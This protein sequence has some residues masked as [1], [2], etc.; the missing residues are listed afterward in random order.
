MTQQL[1]ADMTA[2]AEGEATL[3]EVARG[4][5]RPPPRVAEGRPHA[6]AV[7]GLW[8]GPAGAP[9]PPRLVFRRL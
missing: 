6:G 4:H 5:R 8:R 2:I 9:E 7:P 3:E 1:E